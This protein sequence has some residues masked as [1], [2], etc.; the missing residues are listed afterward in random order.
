MASAA[1]AQARS[2]PHRLP[3][4]HYHGETGLAYW[5]TDFAIGV[6][7]DR[8]CTTGPRRARPPSTSTACSIANCWPTVTCS[9]SSDQLQDSIRWR[10]RAQDLAD[11]INRHC[12]DERDGTFY[13]ADLGLRDRTRRLGSQRRPASLVVIAAPDRQLVELPPDVAGF[14]SRKA[15]QMVS[16]SATGPPS[17]RTNGVRSLS[18]LQKMTTSVIQQ[19]VQLARPDLGNQQLPGLLRLAQVRL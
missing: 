15:E 7:N 14:A 5:Q 9:N 1:P 17:P 8:R 3:T 2:V 11:S 10:R 6:D 16:G 13:S 19:P 18:R 12:W 4:R